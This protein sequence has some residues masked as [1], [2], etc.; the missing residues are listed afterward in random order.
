[1]RV[2]VGFR[3]YEYRYCLNHVYSASNGLIGI[4]FYA[5]LSFYFRGHARVFLRVFAELELDLKMP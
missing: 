2:L 3:P 5:I 1:M 4:N